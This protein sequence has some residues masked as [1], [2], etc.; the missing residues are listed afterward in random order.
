MA[1]NTSSV[2]TFPIKGKLTEGTYRLSPASKPTRSS[3]WRP[4]YDMRSQYIEAVV[5]ADGN[6]T[7]TPVN[8]SAG[9][10]TEGDKTFHQH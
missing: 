6:V 9:W 8:I 2:K 4:K 5:T 7:L 1:V 3:E 10:K